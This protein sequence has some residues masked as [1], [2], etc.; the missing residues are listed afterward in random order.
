MPQLLDY[1]QQ[2]ENVPVITDYFAAAFCLLSSCYLVDMTVPIAFV[3]M[4]IDKI[5][6]DLKTSCQKYGVPP[7][8]FHLV[9]WQC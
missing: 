3:G 5:L 1:S 7:S 4:S 9:C 6:Q 2:A 8:L